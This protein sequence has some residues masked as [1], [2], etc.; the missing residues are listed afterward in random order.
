VEL[1]GER[2]GLVEFD[3]VLACR[4]NGHAVA[5]AGGEWVVRFVIEDEGDGSGVDD[6]VSPHAVGDTVR[7]QETG[8]HAGVV[9]DVGGADVFES[10]RQLRSVHGLT[11]GLQDSVEPA[12]Q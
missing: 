10:V 12:R 8:G 5:G 11:P 7:A 1:D 9:D 3:V 2:G 4:W 6:E